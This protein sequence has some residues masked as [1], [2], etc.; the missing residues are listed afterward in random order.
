MDYTERLRRLTINDQRLGAEVGEAVEL[1]RRTLALVRIA[2]L[3]AVG[4]PEP[5]FGAEADAAVSAGASPSEIVDVL[6]GVV[7]VIGLP[8][9]VAAAPKLALALGCDVGLAPDDTF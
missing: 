8:L 5:S 6:A 3:V 7:P 2:A 9:V 4:G 1:D